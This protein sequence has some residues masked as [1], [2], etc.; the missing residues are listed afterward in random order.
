MAEEHELTDPIVIPEVVTSKYKMV[1]LNLN[2][3]SLT[4]PNTE[5][6]LIIIGLKDNNGVRS[7][8]QYRRSSYRYD[9]N[10]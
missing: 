9:E 3:E 2:M 7:N 10:G 6:G 1:S 4:P 5:P 8:Y